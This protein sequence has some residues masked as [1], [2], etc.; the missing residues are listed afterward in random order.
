[1]IDDWL[2][3]DLHDVEY[4]AAGPSIPAGNPLS[5]LPPGPPASAASSTAVNSN[6]SYLA[7]P[8]V[9]L[10]A[11][12]HTF[13]SALGVLREYQQRGVIRRIG[14]SG[15]P[16]PVLLRLALLALHTT[17][18]PVDIIQSYSHS[19]LLN[20]TLAE[21]YLARLRDEARVGEVV[22]A[23]PLSMSIL[24]SG[25]GP[26]WHPVNRPEGLVVRSALD[27]AKEL[28]TARGEKIEIV[29]LRYGLRRLEEQG[30][31]VPVAAG[32]QTVQQLREMLACYRD[33]RDGRGRETE[34]MVREVFKRRG[35]EG[36]SWASP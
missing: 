36:W 7:P 16:L 34:D 27:E 12:D 22:T 8:Y 14:F 35:V 24:V 19:T 1:M 9:P 23:S 26:E 21:G 32:A 29:A 17:G 20:S 10:G 2:R 25:R 4:I 3:P 33:A 28:C 13:L 5:Y 30:K 15:Y 31:V 18:I 11:G 6:S